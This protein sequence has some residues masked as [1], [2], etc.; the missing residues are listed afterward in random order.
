[1]HVPRVRLNILAYAQAMSACGLGVQSA[2]AL[3]HLGTVKAACGK[4]D[5]LT[6]NAAM[7]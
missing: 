5:V 7:M 4:L 2:E 3:V 6:F 1:M